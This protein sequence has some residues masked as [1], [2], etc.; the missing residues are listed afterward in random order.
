MN[1][2]PELRSWDTLSGFRWGFEDGAMRKQVGIA[3]LLLI[4]KVHC[5]YLMGGILGC[6]DLAYLEQPHL[7]Y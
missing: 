7:E 6:L 5:I 1:R 3:L 2:A 4:I